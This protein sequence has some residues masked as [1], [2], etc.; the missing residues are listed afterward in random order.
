M[1]LELWYPD[2]FHDMSAETKAEVCNGAGAKDG[3]KVPS[4]MY[5]LNC[6]EAFDIH[7]YDYWVGETL[8]DKRWADLR[9]LVNT[10]ILIVNKRGILMYARGMRAMSYFMAVAIAGKKAFFAGKNS[11]G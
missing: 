2:G 4:T 7:D 11:N 5:G 1:K 9:M 3:I 6:L 10:M 8:E